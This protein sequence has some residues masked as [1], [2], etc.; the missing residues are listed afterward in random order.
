MIL[1]AIAFSNEVAAQA[2][3]ASQDPNID[4][5]IRSFL[6]ILNSG[7]GKPIEQLSPKEARAVLSGAQSSVKVDMSGIIVSEKT[8]VADGENIKL[9]IVKPEKAKGILP[10]FMFFHGGGWVLGDFPTHQRMVRDLVVESGAAAVFVNYSPSPEAHYPLAI[11]Q[12]YNATKWV[13]E[14]GKEIGVDGKRLAVAG[15][16]AGGNMATVVALMAKDKKG[17]NIKLQVLFWPVTNADFETESYNLFAKDR[18]LT[19]NLMMWMWD[20]YTTDPKQRKEIYASP[21][22]AT[23]SQLKGLPPALVQTGQND[24]LRDEG[25]AYARKLDEAGVKVT[26]TRYNGM[27]HDWGLLNAL[28]TVPGTKS[29]LLQAASEIKNALK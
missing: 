24:I 4:S 27:I 20:N 16:S 9:N 1:L 28:S 7:T 17:P 18:F 12:A 22:Q 6:K 14:H 13:A 15:N 3:D 21:L 8:I 23:S 29:A 11:N 19:K 26:A 10:V 2:K 25:E 5:N